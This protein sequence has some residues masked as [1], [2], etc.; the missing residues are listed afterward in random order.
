MVY[1][2][3]HGHVMFHVHLDPFSYCFGDLA[4]LFEQHRHVMIP[5]ALTDWPCLSLQQLDRDPLLLVWTQ[6]LG[7]NPHWCVHPLTTLA[8]TVPLNSISLIWTYSS[9]N[10]PFGRHRTCWAFTKHPDLQPHDC[11]CSL[12]ASLC[13]SKQ[14]RLFPFWNVYAYICI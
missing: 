9:T 2:L 4:L 1:S 12:F 10:I 14:V 7:L 5:S 6:S 13:K 11:G 3:P 8:A